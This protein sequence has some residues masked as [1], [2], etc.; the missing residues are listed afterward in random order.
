MKSG[1]GS[2]RWFFG[3][4][5]LGLLALACLVL[6]AASC[7]GGSQGSHVAQL[8]ATTTQQSSTAREVS[9]HAQ[10]VA[11][12]RCMH[13]HGVP[14]WPAPSSNG[15]FAKSALTPG[16]LG[17]GSSQI[18]AAERACKSLLPTPTYSGAQQAHVLAQA[19]RFSRCMRAHGSTNFPDPENNG[20]IVI[21]DA[22]ENTPVYLAALNFCERKYGVPPPPVPT[23][24]GRS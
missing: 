24:G 8:G 23:G 12:A 21:P 18:A 16:Q 22:M 1:H 19:L 2:G 15:A 4:L 13:T 3:R 20:A 11:F 5:G 10:G 7:R 9:A 6:V 17:V 14:L